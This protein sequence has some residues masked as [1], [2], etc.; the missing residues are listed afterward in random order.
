MAASIEQI[1]VQLILKQ[2]SYGIP[3]P[4]TGFHGHLRLLRGRVTIVSGFNRFVFKS[5]NQTW[6]N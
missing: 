6:W 3:Y 1:G 4:S 2:F 5:L